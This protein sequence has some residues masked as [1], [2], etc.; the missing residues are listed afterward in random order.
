MEVLAALKSTD[1]WLVNN[2]LNI[3]FNVLIGKEL[4]KVSTNYFGDDTEFTPPKTIGVCPWGS[5]RGRNS[6]MNSNNRTNYVEYNLTSDNMDNTTHFLLPFNSHLIFVDDGYRRD[7]VTVAKTGFRAKFE[8][9]ISAPAQKNVLNVPLVDLVIG[10]DL[11]TLHEAANAVENDICVL[12]LQGSGFAADIIAHAYELKKQLRNPKLDKFPDQQRQSIE[13]AALTIVKTDGAK[14][15]VPLVEKILS[16]PALLGIYK[17]EED[18]SLS[19]ELMKLIMFHATDNLGKLY[20]S[21]SWR[22]IDLAEELVL[23]NHT[24]IKAKSLYGLLMTALLNNQ[25][26]FVKLL[27]KLGVD[28]QDFLTVDRLHCLYNFARNRGAFVSN[29]RNADLHRRFAKEALPPEE[30]WVIQEAQKYSLH[31]ESGDALRA[32]FAAFLGHFVDKKVQSYVDTLC[33]EEEARLS[34]LT[35]RTVYLSTVAKFLGHDFNLCLYNHD[36]PVSGGDSILSQCRLLLVVDPQINLGFF[37]VI[38][39]LLSYGN[40]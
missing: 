16:K 35:D 14:G 7:E 30:E 23:W 39:K 36:T 9:M 3:T 17:L 21:L 22:K 11:M 15:V 24:D 5:I 18:K 26:D 40:E 8:K 27:L 37:S 33:K 4:S 19:S 28:L 2:G 10:G 32:A 20:L 12:V 31:C 1:A 13:R 25:L 38:E 29:L 6:L 34:R